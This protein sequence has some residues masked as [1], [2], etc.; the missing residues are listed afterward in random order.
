MLHSARLDETSGPRAVRSAGIR[1]RREL[2]VS[3]ADLDLWEMENLGAR[4]G[5]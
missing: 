3:N 2:G 1:R 4:R 5:G